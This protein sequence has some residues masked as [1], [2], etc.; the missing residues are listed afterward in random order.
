MLQL[1]GSALLFCG[2][3]WLGFAAEQEKRGRTEKLRELAMALRMMER[4]L[5]ARMPPLPELL[6]LA[7][8]Q[9]N[10]RL[11]MFFQVCAAFARNQDG[12]FEKH[13]REEAEKLKEE[14]GEQGMCSLLRFGQR[15]GRYGWEE[16][17]RV[18]SLAAADLEEKIRHQE[19]ENG[20]CGP[21]YRTLGA[22]AGALL[23][24]LL[25]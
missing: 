20:R 23:V 18:L 9:T 8:R 11:S 4:E 3:C 13:W 2:A 6:E 12:M 21:L 17:K 1:M 15:L 24:I 22:T 19:Q 10:G 16:E 7:G 14:L 25:L 5:D